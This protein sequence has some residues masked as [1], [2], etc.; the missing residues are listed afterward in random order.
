MTASFPVSVSSVQTCEKKLVVRQKASSEMGKRERERER[1]RR[2]RGGGGRKWGHERRARN[3]T[4]WKFHMQT[5]SVCKEIFAR[6]H[7]A[8]H[9]P[10]SVAEERIPRHY[11]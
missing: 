7:T 5:C 9:K 11:T 2:E 6:K 4:G 8:T 10:T 1:E 3:Q